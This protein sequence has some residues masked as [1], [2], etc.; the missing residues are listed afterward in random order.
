MTILDH[1]INQNG[2]TVTHRKVASVV[3]NEYDEIDTSQTTYTDTS[4]KIFVIPTKTHK[5]EHRLEGKTSVPGDLEALVPSTVTVNEGEQIIYDGDTYKI[6]S[7]TVITYAGTTVTKI[8]LK[9]KL[10]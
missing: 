7:K 10:T 3:Y 1:F 6:E 2:V 9:R 5:F 4:I 8:T